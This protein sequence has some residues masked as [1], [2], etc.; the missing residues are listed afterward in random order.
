[1]YA[2]NAQ[3]I[4]HIG[5]I[6]TSYDVDKLIE[7]LANEMEPD[8]SDIEMYGDSESAKYQMALE[9]SDFNIKGAW[10]GENTPIYVRSLN[11]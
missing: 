8:E 1:M 6:R 2:I 5:Y 10:L 9:Y 7:L 4:G 11:K 3:S